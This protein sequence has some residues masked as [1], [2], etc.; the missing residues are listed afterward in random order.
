[1]FD[2][3][4]TL[5]KYKEKAQKDELGYYPEKVSVRAFPERRYLWTSRFL[6]IVSCLSLCLC[7]ML[8]GVLILC[9]PMR[10]AGVVPLQVDYQRYQISFMNQ[11]ERRAYAGDLVTES[12]MNQY[13]VQRYT[14]SDDK[15]EMDRRLGEEEFVGLSSDDMVYREF[16]MT[17]KPYF[18]KMYNEGI[19]RKVKT[20]L[21]YPVSFDFW[22]VRFETIDKIPNIDKPVK[23]RWIATIRMF[24]DFKKYANDLQ[25]VQR[26]KSLRNPFGLTVTSYNLSYMGE[27]K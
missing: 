14:I 4:Y 23:K 18:E 27:V 7:M 20:T 19:R 2:L 15:D 13:V 24:F 21:I 8:G 12:L 25:D 22:Q 6:V 11:R 26:K 17:E 1:M 3:F 5:F 16:A 10:G 9:I